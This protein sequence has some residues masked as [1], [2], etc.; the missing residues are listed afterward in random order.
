[1]KP[2]TTIATMQSVNIGSKFIKKIDQNFIDHF[3]SND[4]NDNTDN[5]DYNHA[6]NYNNNTNNIISFQS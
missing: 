2:L 5:G 4:D 3:G 1:M 6:A